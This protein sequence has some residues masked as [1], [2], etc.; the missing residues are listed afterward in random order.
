[1]PSVSAER[2]QRAVRASQTLR[3]NETN[4]KNKKCM[5][6]LGLAP[7]IESLQ[8]HGTVFGGTDLAIAS[9]SVSSRMG[10]YFD[11]APIMATLSA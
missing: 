6:A 5:G 8:V 4:T 10:R 7:E 11:T 9:L 1:L 3:K 2:N